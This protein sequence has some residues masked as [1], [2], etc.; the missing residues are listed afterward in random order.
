MLT[1]LHMHSFFSFDGKSSAEDM[2][3]SAVDKGIGSIAFTEH[4]DILPTWAT[5]DRVDNRTEYTAC[6][7]EAYETILSLKEKYTGKLNIIYSIELGQ[8]H[9]DLEASHAFIDAHCFDFVLG[10]IH[11]TRYGNYSDYYFLDYSKQNIPELMEDYYNENAQLVSSGILDSL[12]HLDYP[13]RVMEG[14][15]PYPVELKEYKE[16]V[17]EIMK[18]LVSRNIVLEINTTGLGRWFKRMS[19]ESWV[20]ELYR[21]AGGKFVTVG[22]DTH[23]AEFVGFHSSDAIELAH[24]MGLKVVASFVNRT[25]TEVV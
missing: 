21:E 23:S 17:W 24:S 5:P 19:P 25:I 8:S 11:Q 3:I 20:L 1:D 2:C 12:G 9:H 22:S 16:A 18:L 13:I 10:S 6:D 7:K 14:F 4:Y 15:I